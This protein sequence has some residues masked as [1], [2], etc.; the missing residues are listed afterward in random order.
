MEGGG[1]QPESGGRAHGCQAD[2][3]TR[4]DKQL[5]TF[6]C[7]ENTTAVTVPHVNVL[8]DDSKDRDGGEPG[9]YVRPW[10]SGNCAGLLQGEPRSNDVSTHPAEAAAR[11][12]HRCVPVIDFPA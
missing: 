5:L 2:R 7:S 9:T 1:R 3:G 12:V 4:E 11:F 8:Q 10:L 6:P